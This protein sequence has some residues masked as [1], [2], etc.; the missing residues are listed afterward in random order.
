VTADAP[1]L[2]ITMPTRNRPGLLERA[3]R[4]VVCA[5]APVAE[6]IEVAVSDGSDD[7]ATGDVV[8]R[9]LTG[10]PARYRYVWNRPALSLVE[11]LN[12]AVE[13]STGQW[14]MQLHDDDYL[15]PGAG[16]AMLDAIRRAAPGESV[17]LFG[18]HI[19][20]IDGVRRREQT[21]RSER[22]LEPR[23]ALRRLLRNSSFVR[24]P[25]AV[26]RRTAIEREGLFDPSV[27]GAADTDMWVRLFSRYG[28]R[29]VP[30]ATCAYTI[31]QAAATTGMWNPDTIRDANRIFDRAIARGPVPERTIRRWQADFLHQFILAG[32]YR[33]LRMGRR[34][35][36]RE[37]L[38]LFELPEVHDR[39]VSPKWL[40]VRAA[41]TAA[42]AGPRLK[43]G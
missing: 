4:S 37:V 31:H 13:I 43:A 21:F 5:V 33:R 18:V 34:A 24:A 10:W 28:V 2:S 39:G 9:V 6:N 26:V 36:A 17:L 23:E 29:C 8:G 32:A 41:F 3:L 1:P 16:A 30:Q 22:Y 7:G 12:R 15:L 14:F 11:N 19:V 27:G 35:E 25:T 38:R 20:D 42:T 40:P